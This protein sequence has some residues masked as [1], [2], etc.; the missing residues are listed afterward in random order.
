MILCIQNEKVAVQSAMDASRLV[1]EDK[2]RGQRWELDNDTVFWGGE[3]SITP[4]GFLLGKN[5]DALT[6]V[7][8]F[9]DGVFEDDDATATRN[10]LLVNAGLRT[11]VDAIMSV[12][13]VDKA[14]AQQKAAVILKEQN[15]QLDDFP[16]A[17]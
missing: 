14:I 17:D 3:L 4:L 12:D 7:I 5:P 6:P 1:I 10:V 13:R 11:R 9:D 8:T 2:L 16:E 15:G